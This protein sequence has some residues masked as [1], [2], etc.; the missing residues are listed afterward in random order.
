MNTCNLCNL[1]VFG[2]FSYETVS[3][4]L[5]V[6]DLME[7]LSVLTEFNKCYALQSAE[8][9]TNLGRLKC[10]IYLTVSGTNTL[11]QNNTSKSLLTFI[12]F[13]VSTLNPEASPKLPKN[14]SSQKSVYDTLSRQSS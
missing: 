14:S 7:K 2:K 9:L 5:T 8:S 1:R 6:F 4:K 12:R 11:F 3:V 13:T 10:N